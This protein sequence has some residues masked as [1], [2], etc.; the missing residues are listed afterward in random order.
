MITLR[1]LHVDKMAAAKHKFALI[2]ML[3]TF[4]VAWVC[5]EF[6]SS[7]LIMVPRCPLWEMQYSL[8]R[9]MWSS[10]AIRRDVP[11]N[12]GWRIIYSGSDLLTD[13]NVDYRDPL[14][15]E[16]RCKGSLKNFENGNCD[17]EIV[18]NDKGYKGNLELHWPCA[19]CALVC[20]YVV[21]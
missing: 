10:S 4:L 21:I 18:N 12:F 16:L 3:E 5:T 14:S 2:N 20:H 17:F 19:R 11:D 15:G 9:H 8:R 13:L 7:N 6:R 1:R